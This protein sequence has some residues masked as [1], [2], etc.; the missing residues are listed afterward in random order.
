MPEAPDRSWL[1]DPTYR[2]WRER[3]QTHIL[4]ALESSGANC[5]LVSDRG[6]PDIDYAV[7][8]GLTILL[9]KPLI[10]VSAPGAHIPQRLRRAADRV[11]EI[12]L[13]QPGARE[14]LGRAVNDVLDG[15][16]VED[17]DGG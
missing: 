2:S 13:M 3:I 17:D 5:M 14:E 15:I 4:P 12:D 7:E 9:D 6:D 10:V 8:L 16:D 1:S 11:I